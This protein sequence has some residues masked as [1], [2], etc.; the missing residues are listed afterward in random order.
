MKKTFGI[1]GTGYLGSVIAEAWEKGFLEDWTL[2]GVYGRNEEKTAALAAKHSVKACASIEELIALRPDYI[3]EA[4]SVQ[5]VKDN[6]E[7]I[8]SASIG[9]VLLSIGSLADVPFKERVCKLAKERG[10]KI[11]LASGAVGGFDVLRTIALM[12]ADNFSFH[13]Q[14]SAKALLNTPIANDHMLT[15]TERK[16]AFDGTASEAIELL[17]TKVN[18]AV[19]SALASIGPERTKMSIETVPGF[20]G[21]EYTLKTSAPGVWAEIEIYSATSEI[22]AWSVVAQLKN[23]T[24]P[25][26]F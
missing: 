3:A 10:V 14:K 23:I 12:G 15:D 18:V 4:A 2:V 20:K 19:A 8:L 9:M 13:S 26:V 11:H 17:P 5:G 22:A 7:K 6:A 1:F 16:P 24:E 25:L 21:D